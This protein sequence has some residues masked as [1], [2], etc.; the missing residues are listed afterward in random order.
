MQWKPPRVSE[1]LQTAPRTTTQTVKA[2]EL[3]FRVM[4]EAVATFRECSAMPR[5][6]R[7][8]SRSE[9]GSES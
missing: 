4:S 2:F 7:I 9:G 5:F 3:N 1:F 6:K 8:I